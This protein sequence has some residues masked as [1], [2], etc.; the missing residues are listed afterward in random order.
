MITTVS[1][2]FVP[3]SSLTGYW[4]MN[5]TDIRNSEMDQRGFWHFCA[6]IVI[7]IALLGMLIAMLRYMH[8]KAASRKKEREKSER[9]ITGPANKRLDRNPV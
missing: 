4:G 2:L 8:N 7:S 5:L 1:L 9:L 6:S 3:F